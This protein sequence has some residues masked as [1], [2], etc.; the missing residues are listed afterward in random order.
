MSD[1]TKQGPFNEDAAPPVGPVQLNAF[2]DG[3]KDAAEHHKIGTRAALPA[4]APANKNWLYFCSDTF[5]LFRSDGTAWTWVNKPR[6]IGF[7]LTGPDEQYGAGYTL[8]S[9]RKAPWNAPGA[10]STFDSH[11]GFSDANDRYTVPASLA[12]WWR[13]H[14]REQVSS[15]PAGKYC[16][17]YLRTNVG[18]AGAINERIA[19]VVYN[20]SATTTEFLSG[21]LPIFLSAGDTLEIHTSSDDTGALHGPRRWAGF[22]LGV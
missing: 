14:Y 22:Y 13:M 4:A 12:G 21:D 2:E 7:S 3:I 19:Q 15:A 8:N 16:H 20:G 11:G 10:G 18:G 6:A 9:F 5:E 1:Y 17:A